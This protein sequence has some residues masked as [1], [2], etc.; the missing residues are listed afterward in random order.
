VR[1]TSV[2]WSVLVGSVVLYVAGLGF[3]YEELHVMATAGLLMVVLAVAW[4]WWRPGVELER[5][6]VP[7]RVVRGEPAEAQLTITNPGRRSLPPLRARDQVGGRP[8]DALLPRT[9]AGTTCRASFP[10]PTERR[11]VVEVGPLQVVRQDPLALT[12]SA[13]TYGTTETLWVYPRV[14]RVAPLSSGKR[15]DLEGPTHD[16]AS[17]SITFHA[18]RE[19]VTGDDLRLIHW[20]STARTGTLMVRQQ[21]DPSQPQTTIVLDTLRSSYEGDAFEDAVEAAA[22]LVVASTSRRFPVRLHTGGGLLATGQGRG[23]RAGGA[24]GAASLLEH[25]TPLQTG[26]TSSL[27]EAATRL[28]TQSGGN[29]LVIISGNPDPTDLMAVETLRNRYLTM[30]VLRFQPGVAPG[31]AWDQGVVDL[32][33]PDAESF[34]ALWNDRT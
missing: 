7:P 17:G 31:L 2:G 3:G 25:L 4:T 20:R 22:S 15:R 5:A 11:G 10:L 19:Y 8:V 30:A 16:G 9:A 28:S 32:V 26:D 13:R 12:Q 34:A 21:A 1:L 6:V 33:A 27:V 24:S 18:L 14:H 29:T 23:G